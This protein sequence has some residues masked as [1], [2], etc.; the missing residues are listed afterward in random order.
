MAF[1]VAIAFVEEIHY[2]FCFVICTSSRTIYIV[3]I[4]FDLASFVESL[5]HI[6][7]IAA[8]AD[9]S[10]VF[11]IIWRFDGTVTTINS[12]VDNDEDNEGNNIL[13]RL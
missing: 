9:V 1:I 3:T 2:L 11:W 7:L 6:L 4:L 10:L 12:R 8:A 5:L 13:V